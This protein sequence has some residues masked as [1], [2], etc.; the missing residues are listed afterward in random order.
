MVIFVKFFFQAIVI[1]ITA[2]CTAVGLWGTALLRTEFDP[3][4]LL[5]PNSYLKEFVF[6]HNRWFPSVSNENS[7]HDVKLEDVKQPIKKRQ[8]A[9]LANQED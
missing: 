4:K 8:K 7:H 1:L 3:I 5:P 9:S 2:F 6:A